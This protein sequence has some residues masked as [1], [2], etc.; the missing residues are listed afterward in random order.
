MK[1]RI[2]FKKKQ[3]GWGWYPATWQGW[4]VTGIYMGLV[5]F[6][7]LS[8]DENSPVNEIVFTFILPLILL[9]LGFIRIAYKMGEKPEWQWG[10]KK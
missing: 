2:W 4:I 10:N 8:I 7:G 9:T 1:K 6:F 3:Y 5:I